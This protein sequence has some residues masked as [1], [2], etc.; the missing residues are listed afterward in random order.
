MGEKDVWRSEG[1]VQ[2]G[3]EFVKTIIR[4]LIEEYKIIWKVKDDE[5]DLQEVNT[6]I[7]DIEEI[8]EKKFDQIVDKRFQGM[9]AD[10]KRKRKER[11]DMEGT[12]PEFTLKN[13]GVE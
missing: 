6:L 1:V 11:M 9:R 10:E 13:K 7:S 4:R 8:L 2:S 12:R 5:I 3:K